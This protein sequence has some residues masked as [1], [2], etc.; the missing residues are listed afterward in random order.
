MLQDVPSD[1]LP[2]V[3]GL[4][5]APELARLACTCRSLRTGANAACKRRCGG[6]VERRGAAEGWPWLA[7]TLELPWE[8]SAGGE[9][10]LLR[11]DGA[12][13]D[14]FVCG[15][16]QD[17]RLGVTHGRAASG[18]GA[19]GFRSLPASAASTMVADMYTKPRALHLIEPGGASSPSGPA[20]ERRHG[21]AAASG[22]THHISAAS[23]SACYISAAAEHTLLVTNG[24]ALL[25][26]GNGFR[27]RLGRGTEERQF[28]PLP[29]SWPGSP[30]QVASISAG[31]VASAAVTRDGALWTFGAGGYG[32]L[33]HGDTETSLVPRRV[34][35]LVDRV[36]VSVSI[37]AGVAGAQTFSPQPLVQHLTGRRAGLCSVLL[38]GRSAADV[39]P[40]RAGSRQRQ[41][42]P[43]PA[44]ARHPIWRPTRCQAGGRCGCWRGR[45]QPAEHPRCQV[46]RR[47]DRSSV[48]AMTWVAL[49]R[50]C[51]WRHTA[52]LDSEGGVW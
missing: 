14:A 51:G 37:G 3:L 13:A 32:V 28:T 45:G 30:Q 26:C 46:R 52:A 22:S 35:A 34:E 48:Y 47:L 24:G 23:G 33:G 19:G 6:V 49:G 12:D 38:C 1:L 5:P 16:A 10:T 9:T 18:P 21:G 15:L 17:G 50:S 20:A 41:R 2:A 39:G 4:L 25:A 29:V 44:H 40:W 27:G 31:A 7:M 42:L 11:G 43:P 36:V 8:V